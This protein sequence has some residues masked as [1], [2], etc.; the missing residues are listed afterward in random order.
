M[1]LLPG[2]EISAIFEK[3]VFMSLQRHQMKVSSFYCS[4]LSIAYKSLG[5]NQTLSNEGLSPSCTAKSTGYF[6]MQFKEATAIHDRLQ[7]DS[8]RRHFYT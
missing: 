4:C 6:D 5:Y 7:Q 1:E 3:I 2:N 8:G